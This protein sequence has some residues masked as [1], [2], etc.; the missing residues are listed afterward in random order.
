MGPISPDAGPVSKNIEFVTKSGDSPG[1]LLLTD[2]NKLIVLDNGGYDVSLSIDQDSVTNLPIGSFFYVINV[3]T[4]SARITRNGSTEFDTIL[5]NVDFKIDKLV[6][7]TGAKGNL[8]WG[9]KKTT[10]LWWFFGPIKP[11]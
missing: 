9:I 2:Q 6:S 5:G 10:N 1:S 11:V 8:V 3:G 4:G 7:S